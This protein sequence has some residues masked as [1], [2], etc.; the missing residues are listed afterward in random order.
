MQE[1][2]ASL[3]DKGYVFCPPQQAELTSVTSTRLKSTA[4]D[5]AAF[6][7]II[8]VSLKLLSGSQWHPGVAFVMVSEFGV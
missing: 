1:L 3:S 4:L 7:T 2:K 5:D 6:R 8:S